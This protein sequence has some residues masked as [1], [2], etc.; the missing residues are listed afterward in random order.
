MKK[1]SILTTPAIALSV[2]VLCAPSVLAADYT[3]N[4]TNLDTAAATPDTTYEGVFCADGLGFCTLSEGDWTQEGDIDLST[5]EISGMPIQGLVL[6]NNVNISNP[7][8]GTITG[9][10]NIT[11]D[12]VTLNDLNVAGG[13]TIQNADA[14]VTIN[15]GNYT[16]EGWGGALNID[17]ANSVTT[18]DANFNAAGASAAY[19]GAGNITVNGGSFVSEGD[20]GIEFFG[21]HSLN[22]TGGTFTGFASGLAFD[23]IPDG[24]TV[25]LSGGTF[26]GTGT[27][28]NAIIVYNGDTAAISNMLADGHYFT[29]DTIAVEPGLGGGA[30]IAGTTTVTNGEEEGEEEPTDPVAPVPA[31]KSGLGAPDT[32]VFTA[33]E[34]SAT[35]SSLLTVMATMLVAL[36]G[37]IL[38]KKYSKR[39]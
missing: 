7:D 16:A 10:I 5:V 12:E 36:T 28:G 38:V 1:L 14:E 17:N 21:F 13:V 19:I 3:L 24:S 20:N 39:A 8:D 6:Q 30:Y 27:N 9:N 37:A 29:N 32:G 35:S 22:I 34:G 26:T 4:Q 23:G 2:G 33:E 25:S 31:K 15:G 18:N 11:A